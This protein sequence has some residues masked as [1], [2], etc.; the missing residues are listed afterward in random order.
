MT[1]QAIRPM[2]DD[3]PQ[4]SSPGTP[5]KTARPASLLRRW[6]PAITEALLLVSLYIGYT[7]SR[8]LADN[9]LTAAMGHA[10]SVLR[11]ETALDIDIEQPLNAAL[12]HAQWLE[13]GSSYWYALLHYLVTPLVLVL[14]WRRGRADYRKARTA[15]VIATVAALVGYLVYP[16]APPRLL[17]GYTDVLSATSTFG[18]WGAD[19]SAPRGLGGTT[20][21]LAAMPSMHVGW[22]VWVA[23]ML[24][25][26]AQHR[27]QRALAYSYAMG[28]M[29]VVV[30]TANHWVLDGVVGAAIMGM[31]L[32]L[33]GVVPWA[34]RSSMRVMRHCPSGNC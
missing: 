9:D 11:L 27:W 21:E 12:T 29:L 15:L 10:E 20:N 3:L 24:A 25:G 8:L 2:T 1:I 14:M 26:M 18:W 31:S 5:S 4:T 17:P 19:A 22:A 30:V 34:V 13:I 7:L 32:A 33:T 28:T 16:T 6:A 23:V